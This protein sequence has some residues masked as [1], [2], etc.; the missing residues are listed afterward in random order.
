MVHLIRASMRFGAYNDRREVAA[1]L[2]PVYTTPNAEAARQALEAFADSPLG[3]KYP[4]APT[5]G[6]PARCRRCECPRLSGGRHL[7]HWR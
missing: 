1:A 7:R 2:K 6:A 4:T 5:A 3:A